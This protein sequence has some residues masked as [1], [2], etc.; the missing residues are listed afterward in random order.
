MIQWKK[1]ERE[2]N[3]MEKLLTVDEAADVMRCSGQTIRRRIKAGELN[4]VRNGRLLFVPESS[5]EDFYKRNA[6]APQD[7]E[8]AKGG[9]DQ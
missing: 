6:T 4:A 1:Y 7:P 8:T 3:H 5:I 9:G 2:V